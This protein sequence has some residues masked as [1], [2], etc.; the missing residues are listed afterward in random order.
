MKI[1]N[2]PIEVLESIFNKLDVDDFCWDENEAWID[3]DEYW[4]FYHKIQNEITFRMEKAKKPNIHQYYVA[5][6][7]NTK[8][9]IIKVTDVRA[10]YAFGNIYSYDKYDNNIDIEVDY[11]MDD[12]PTLVALDKDK[13]FRL[14]FRDDE[15]G[16]CYP[17][18]IDE[19]EYNRLVNT[20]VDKWNT[21][22]D[23][24]YWCPRF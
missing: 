10:G 17:M 15:G 9:F 18:P 5:N 16:S 19:N 20:P 2:A 22:I 12:I 3:V 6:V 1:E 4:E 13:R 8:L 7:N 21:L 24:K 23:T 14:V 11:L